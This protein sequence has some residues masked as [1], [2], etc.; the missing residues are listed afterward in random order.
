MTSSSIRSGG[1]VR[2]IS[3]AIFSSSSILRFSSFKALERVLASEPYK[4]FVDAEL[5]AAAQVTKA[6]N[7]ERLAAP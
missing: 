2:W 1:S 6:W 5:A 3:E 4:S 7:F